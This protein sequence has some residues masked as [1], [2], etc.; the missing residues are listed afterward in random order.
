MDMK[1]YTRAI[2]LY[3]DYAYYNR[4]INYDILGELELDIADTIRSVN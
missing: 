1:D 4:S 2:Y 3:P